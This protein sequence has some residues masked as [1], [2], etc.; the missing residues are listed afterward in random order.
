MCKLILKETHQTLVIGS[1]LV[2]TGPSPSSWLYISLIY[3]FFYLPLIP[4]HY[5]LDPSLIED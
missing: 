3:H 2:P 1:L 4:Q 5:S